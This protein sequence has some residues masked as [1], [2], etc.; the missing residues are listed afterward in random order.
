MI[1]GA[2][3][4]VVLFLLAPRLAVVGLAV[5]FAASTVVVYSTIRDRSRDV[6]ALSGLSDR[7]WIDRAARGPVTYLNATAYEQETREGRWFEEW[8]PVWESEFW[9]RRFDGVLTLGERVGAG[10]VLPALRDARLGNGPHRGRRRR[11]IASSIR[12]SRRSESSS[13][14]ARAS[15]L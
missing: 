2:V 6:L 7:T 12:A 10:A 14:R 9:N 1:G 8:L 13:P 11:P 15:A 3:A 4:S 5:F